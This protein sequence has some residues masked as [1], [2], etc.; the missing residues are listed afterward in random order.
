[1]KVRDIMTTDPQCCTPATSLRDAARRMLEYDCGCIPVVETLA[2]GR[3]VGVI[4]DRDITCRM[5]AQGASATDTTVVTCMTTSCI[6]VTP[7]MSVKECCEVLERHQ[8]R[9]APVIDETGRVCGI[10]AQ[11]DIALKAGRKVAE[12]VK[13]VSK[14]TANASSVVSDGPATILGYH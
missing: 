8:I 7:D 1:M 14:P 13:E 12:V 2:S 4:T 5:V 3:L 6:T 10:V 11:A 9:R